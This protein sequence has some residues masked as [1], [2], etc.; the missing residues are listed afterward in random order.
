MDDLSSYLASLPSS[1]PSCTSFVIGNEACDLDSVISSI[2]YAYYLTITTQIITLPI[3]CVVKEDLRLRTEIVYFL[4]KMEV[5]LDGLLFLDTPGVVELREKDGISVSLVD[6]NKCSNVLQLKSHNI[7]NIVDHH[8]DESDD[9]EG[10]K[11]IEMVG[12]CCT[13]IGDQLLTSFEISEISE[14]IRVLLY[15]T[16]LL[17]TINL[18]WD[19]GRTTDKDVK[20]VATLDCS[21]LL[22]VKNIYSELLEAK[23]DISDLSPYDLLRKDTK[24]VFEGGVRCFI[25]SITGI[26]VEMFMERSPD[27]GV[28]RFVRE[29]NADLLIVMLAHHSEAG[30][31]RF[32]L[33]PYGFERIDGVEGFMD[34]LIEKVDL[35]VYEGYDDVYHHRK[36]KESR[37]LVLPLVKAWLKKGSLKAEL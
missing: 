35:V 36:V 22:L 2:V 32:L 8:V 34:D 26:N 33:V 16:I 24:S 10:E 18:D 7:L 21:D 17:D 12:S 15:S 29:N 20:M 1:L 6:H 23:I 13:L 30:F 31:E 27:E 11:V 5:D 14:D 9:V 28:E 37:K 19:K 4:K 25:A 3:V